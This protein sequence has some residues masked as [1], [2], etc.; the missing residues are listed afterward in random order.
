MEEKNL[1]TATEDENLNWSEGEKTTYTKEEVDALTKEMQSNSDKWV[2]K[3]ISEKKVYE[4]VLDEVW[5]VADDKKYLVELHESSPEVAAIIL[6]K[7]YEWKSIEEYKEDIDY[8][9]DYTDPKV[10]ER[11][12]EKKA[13]EV[14]EQKAIKEAKKNF[15]DKF[16]LKWEELDWFESAL[17][18]RMELK[19]FKS[20]DINKH[21]NKAFLEISDDKTFNEIKKT[22]EIAWVMGTSQGWSS[23]TTSTKTSKSDTQSEARNFVNT[24]IN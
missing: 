10:V 11:L 2:Q 24:F 16:K 22:K 7:Y 5:K 19:S 3:I 8:K 6:G 18:E 12:V 9:E 17:L 13:N 23:W 21:L 14:A 1:E 4:Q 15:I 20:S